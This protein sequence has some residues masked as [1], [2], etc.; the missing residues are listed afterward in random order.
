MGRPLVEPRRAGRG[1][2][3]RSL[4]DTFA[5]DATTTAAP[6]V[7]AHASL[8]GVVLGST[9]ETF[10]VGLAARRRGRSFVVAVVLLYDLL[11]V[12]DQRHLIAG[13]LL[14]RA[15]LLRVV[16]SMPLLRPLESCLGLR[17]RDDHR[18]TCRLGLFRGHGIL[19]PSPFRAGDGL[20]LS[21]IHVV[22]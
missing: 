13:R 14:G 8:V 21:T 10:A 20:G 4:L 11:A 5:N 3:E 18:L 16:E 7:Q 2:G 19:D 17:S 15:D 9:V 22:L 6:F 12:I 1:C